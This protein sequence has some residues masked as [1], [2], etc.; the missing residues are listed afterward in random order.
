[1]AGQVSPVFFNSK[2]SINYHRYPQ[3]LILCQSNSNRLYS[4]TRR[5]ACISRILRKEY[6]LAITYFSAWFES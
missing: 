1:M 5:D 6:M 4:L 3:R 2:H